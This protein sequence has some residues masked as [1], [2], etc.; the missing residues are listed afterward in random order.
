MSRPVH[1]TAHLCNASG[2]ATESTVTYIVQAQSKPSN[3]CRHGVD[4]GG[5]EK[6]ETD[7]SREI[8]QFIHHN[9]KQGTSSKTKS[10]PMMGK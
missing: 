8:P 6:N 3:V 5:R 7:K 1:L 9:L 10:P 2:G 4:Q